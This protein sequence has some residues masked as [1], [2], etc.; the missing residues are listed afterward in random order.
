MEKEQITALVSPD[1]EDLEKLSDLH[2]AMGDHT[3]LKIFCRLMNGEVCVGDLAKEMNLTE[4]AVSHQLRALK[5][6]RL[7]RYHKVGKNVFYVLEDEHIKWIL[8]ETY[9]HISER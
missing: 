9:A 8:E 5:N 4:S 7:I 2:K 6:V 1:N 3:R